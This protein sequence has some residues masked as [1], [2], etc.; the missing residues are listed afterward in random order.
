ME[1]LIRNNIYGNGPVAVINTIGGNTV[2]IKYKEHLMS[3]YLSEKEGLLF[4]Q[5][6]WSSKKGE[7]EKQLVK[8]INSMDGDQ[9]LNT[10]TT[11]LTDYYI[12]KYSIEV[13]KLR[14]DEIVVD[15]SETKIDVSGDLRYGVSNRSR[16]FFVLGLSIH[17]E[18]PVSG[19]AS[20]FHIRPSTYTLNPP[21]AYVGSGKLSFSIAGTDLTR[22]KVQTEIDRRLSS[23]NQYLERLSNDVRGFNDGLGALA[24]QSI[25]RRKEKLL[26][27]RELVAGLGY[28]LKSRPSQSNTFPTSK[29]RREIQS[30]PPEP[31][32][33][34]KP[35]SPEPTLAEKDYEHILSVM[36]NMTRVMEQSPSAFSEMGEEHLRFHFL[37]QLNGLY[38]GN[39]TGET[40]NYEGKTDILIKE[41]GRNIFIGECKYWTGRAGYLEALDQVLSYLSWRDT[42]AAVLVF[43]RNKNFSGVLKN[44][45]EATPTHKLYK[46]LK[47]NRSE[48]SWTYLFG[49][50]DDPNREI[51]ITVLAFDVP[52]K[53]VLKESA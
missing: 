8:E 25:E 39:A 19:E 43:N 9:L 22:E 42:K 52:V 50:K 30:R 4:N 6:D 32:A 5:L 17:V 14:Q 29:V 20:A 21:R 38:E 33:P 2:L 16:P 36:E 37:V 48:S 7:I 27:D 13:P 26:N 31:K 44:I 53:G 3:N 34:G 12:H 47:K 1:T 24:K 10:S 45:Q 15:Q 51:T 41:N 35:Y 40:F 11:D 46:K 18:V 49:H 28:N 23:I